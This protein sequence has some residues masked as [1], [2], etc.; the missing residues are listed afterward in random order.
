MK[1]IAHV[2]LE[3]REIYIFTANGDYLHLGL[4]SK[5]LTLSL[6]CSLERVA[7]KGEMGTGICLLFTGKMVLGSL[8]LEIKTKN[9]NGTGMWAYNRLWNGI[10]AKFWLGNG[11][12]KPFQNPPENTTDIVSWRAL[13]IPSILLPSAALLFIS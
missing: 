2:Y 9:G 10:W 1:G 11:I 7:R 12:Y 6:L 5:K 4:F 3:V 13:N 8:V